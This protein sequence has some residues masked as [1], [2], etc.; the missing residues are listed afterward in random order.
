MIRWAEGIERFSQTQPAQQL[1]DLSIFQSR[2]VSTLKLS[3]RG[4]GDALGPN[5]TASVGG[6]VICPNGTTAMDRSTLHVQL[7]LIWLT[8]VASVAAY[9]LL[10]LF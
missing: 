2:F 1:F 8:L 7:S 6:S 10:S 3:V 9:V 4:A 5:R